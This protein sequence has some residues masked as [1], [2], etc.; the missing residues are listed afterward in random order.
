[1][2]PLNKGNNCLFVDDFGVKCFS[3]YDED[4]LLESLEKHYAISTDW[5]GSHY[6]GLTIFWNYNKAYVDISMPDNATKILERIQYPNPKRPL[7]APHLWT[8]PAYEKILHMASDPYESDLLEKKAP[9]AFNILLVPF[10][11][12]P[13]QLIQQCYE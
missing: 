6:L 12:I 1:M 10:Y 11:I 2:V 8:I 9:S 5:E 13:D 4:H 7:Y 3:R